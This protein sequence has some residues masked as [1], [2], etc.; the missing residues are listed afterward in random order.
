MIGTAR[1]QDYGRTFSGF[2]ANERRVQRSKLSTSR[3]MA[4]HSAMRVSK[5]E[6]WLRHVI[7]GI[8]MPRQSSPCNHAKDARSKDGPT[9][10]QLRPEADTAWR[11]PAGRAGSSTYKNGRRHAARIARFTCGRAACRV[12]FGAWALA[13]QLRPKPLGRRMCTKNRRRRTRR[14][15]KVQ[16]RRKD[17]AAPRRGESVRCSFTFCQV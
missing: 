9:L 10:A 6:L 14:R 11:W 4:E 12:G 3:R 16:S 13:V 15:V 2:G 17:L 5:V 7:K 1:R 8:V